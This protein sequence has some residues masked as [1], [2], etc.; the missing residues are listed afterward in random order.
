LIG[1]EAT[2]EQRKTIYQ[3]FNHNN[4]NDLEM[5]LCVTVSK[6]SSRLNSFKSGNR[7]IIKGIKKCSMSNN[8][9]N[10]EIDD[11]I[12]QIELKLN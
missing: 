3:K 10:G 11:A 5:V 4:T 1:S 6:N 2:A 7:I 9:L 8:A 12:E